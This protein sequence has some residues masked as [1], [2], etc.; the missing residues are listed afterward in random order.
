MKK[1]IKKIIAILGIVLF[2]LISGLTALIFF[3]QALFAH[4]YTYENFTIFHDLDF[5]QSAFNKGLN[6][7]NNLVKESELFDPSYQFEVFIAHK[8][9]FNTVDDKVLGDWSVARA[10]DNNIII[11]KKIDVAAG[12]VENGVNYFSLAY[13]IAHEMVHC[14]QANKYGKLKFNP[15]KHPPL[16]KLEGYPEYIARADLLKRET[17]HLSLGIKGFLDRTKGEFEVRDII[18]LSTNESTPY[19]YYKGRLMTEYLMDIKGMT[20][21]EILKDNRS[22]A[23]VFGAMMTW[24]KTYSGDN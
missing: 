9:R 4:S 14:L 7:A 17:Y 10:I 18:Q 24:F 8:N 6:Q 23:E 22:E 11:K 21:D 19:L 2:V 1:I 20:Y 3:P 16:W 12:T 5:D 15:F 13:V